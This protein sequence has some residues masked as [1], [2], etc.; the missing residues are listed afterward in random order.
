MFPKPFIELFRF[1]YKRYILVRTKQLMSIKEQILKA[2]ID[3]DDQ[4]QLNE[5]LE[6]LQKLNSEGDKSNVKR[7]M[8][9]TGRLSDEEAKRLHD[10]LDDEFNKIEGE[11]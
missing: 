9:F 2:I 1:C 6:Y 7:I 4:R 8:A 5:L 3:M 10:S 11:W